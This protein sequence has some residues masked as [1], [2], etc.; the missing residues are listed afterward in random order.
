MYFETS[1]R[2]KVL[3]SSLCMSSI[4]ESFVHFIIFCDCSECIFL[5]DYPGT[6]FTGTKSFFIKYL[7]LLDLGRYPSQDQSCMRPLFCFSIC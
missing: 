6:L 1:T 4:P 5:V 3:V 7:M 2:K